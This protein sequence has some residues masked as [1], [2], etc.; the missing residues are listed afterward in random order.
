MKGVW[1]KEVARDLVALG[2]VPFFV[3]VLV[4]V[5]MLNNPVYF[6]Q[7]VTSGVVFGLMFLWIRQDVYAGLG[8]IVLVFTS[9]YYGDFLY[10]VF[11]SVAY[12][13]LVVSLFYLEKDWR[14][15]L[16]GVVVGG[17]S[18]A[19]SFIYPNL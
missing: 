13:L 16:F 14:K 19:I 7:F 10:V 9:L 12:C 2:S 6:L 1:L 5:W 4:R 3:L 17:I 8:L 11:G 18:I 15:I